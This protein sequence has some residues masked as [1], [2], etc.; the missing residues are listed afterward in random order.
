[1]D[2]AI[3]FRSFQLFLD[4]KLNFS[5]LI[6]LLWFSKINVLRRIAN[7]SFNKFTL[8]TNCYLNYVSSTAEYHHSAFTTEFV[9]LNLLLKEISNH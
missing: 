1:M 3:H 4:S 6:V 7:Q 9:C 2:D 5:A 8:N